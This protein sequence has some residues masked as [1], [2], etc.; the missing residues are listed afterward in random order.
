[1]MILI[2]FIAGALAGAAFFWVISRRKAALWDD[3]FH[4]IM[5]ELNNLV[6]GANLIVK[7]FRQG[8]FGDV[9]PAHVKW[10]EMLDDHIGRMSYATADLRDMASMSY[11]G[12]PKPA[13]ETVNLASI[14]RELKEKYGS[15]SAR[16]DIRL[17]L[18][19]QGDPAQVTGDA[20]MI[21]R[22]MANLI[23]RGFRL[24]SKSKAIKLCV[25][26][27]PSPSAKDC[28][29]PIS[30]GMADCWVVSLEH[31]CAFAAGDSVGK[32]YGAH[33]LCFRIC[34][35]LL[36]LHGSSLRVE[37][38]GDGMEKISFAMRKYSN[39]KTENTHN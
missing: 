29:F 6:T 13:G 21:E 22:I 30:P 1:M 19:I 37:D 38:A 12:L 7:N 18:D 35:K 20:L 26:A 32:I 8:I 24:S 17:L 16:T 5:H 27:G 23:E 11:E 36:E 25:K 31:H 33:G 14:A 4:H 39:G 9:P 3:G 15:V 10:M 28:R 2:A 34:R